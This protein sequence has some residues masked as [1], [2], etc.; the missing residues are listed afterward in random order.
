MVSPVRSSRVRSRPG[1]PFSGLRGR[2]DRTAGLTPPQPATINR[3]VTL[4]L[5]Y[6]LWAGGNSPPGGTKPAGN[7][8]LTSGE[9]RISAHIRLRHRRPAPAANPQPLPRHRYGGSA[10]SSGF[11]LHSHAT[12]RYETQSCSP[13]P[14]QHAAGSTRHSQHPLPRRHQRRTRL[15]TPTNFRRPPL[16]IDTFWPLRWPGKPMCWSPRT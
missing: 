3:Y 11:A 2:A 16:R 5:I 1:I 8:R 15:R 13:D 4:C 6:E 10:R 14:R 7:R 12:G 9:R